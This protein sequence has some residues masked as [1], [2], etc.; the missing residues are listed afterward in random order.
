MRLLGGVTG[1]RP[2]N[3]LAQDRRGRLRLPYW[4]PKV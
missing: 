3:S 4:E 2:S 1:L